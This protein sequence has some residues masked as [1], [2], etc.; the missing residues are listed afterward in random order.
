M[1]PELSEILN[2]EDVL[3]DSPLDNDESQP[4]G[5]ND[6]NDSESNGFGFLFD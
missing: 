6:G 3:A 5:W 1:T 2:L 4:E